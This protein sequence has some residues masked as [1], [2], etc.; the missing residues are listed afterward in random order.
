MSFAN[1]DQLLELAT[2]VSSRHIGKTLEE[3]TSALAAFSAPS[4]DGAD[5][6]IGRAI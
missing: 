5:A 6:L 4:N 2:L 3:V 1:V